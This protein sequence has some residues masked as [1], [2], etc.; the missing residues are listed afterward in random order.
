MKAWGSTNL[1]WQIRAKAQVWIHSWLQIAISIYWCDQT[2]LSLQLSCLWTNY[3]NHQCWDYR[4]SSSCY[5][6]FSVILKW[7]L[8]VS[9][10]W[11]FT[12]NSF[13]LTEPTCPPALGPHLDIRLSSTESAYSGNQIWWT[14]SASMLP[15]SSSPPWRCVHFSTLRTV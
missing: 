8:L 10:L 13:V 9:S 2:H 1:K 5:A 11:T 14:H 15:L 12:A 3:I 6:P 4:V 7:S